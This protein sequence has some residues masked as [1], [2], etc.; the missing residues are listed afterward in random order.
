[1]T[2]VATFACGCF[3]CSEAIFK[4]LRGVQKVVPGYSGGQMDRPSYEQVSTGQTGHVE[5][6]QITFDPKEVSYKDLVYVFFHTHDPTTPNQ[7]GPDVGPQYRSVIFY[8]DDSQK[9]IAQEQLSEAQRSYKD[10]IVTELVP[11][12]NFYPAEDYHLDYYA[13]N[14]NAMYCKIVIDPKIQKLK[15]NF[16][17][18]LK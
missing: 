2:E 9:K 15:K 1:M 7:Q 8:H 14:P 12:E 6:I 13:N 17:N 4:S 16:G 11:Y 5:A 3:W 18:Y 10:K